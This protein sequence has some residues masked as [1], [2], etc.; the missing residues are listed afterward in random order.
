MA[1]RTTLRET[2]RHCLHRLGVL[3]PLRVLRHG[4]V[5]R[6]V[7]ETLQDR[8]THIYDAGIWKTAPTDP[9]SGAGSHPDIARRLGARLPALVRDLG[10][11]HFLDVGCGDFGW[12]KDVELGCAYTG[13]DIV[14]H[15]VAQ[16]AERF[17]REDRRFLLLNAVEDPLPAADIV[18]CREVLFHLSFADARALLRNVCRSGAGWLLATTDSVTR[19][20]ADIESGDFRILNLAAAPFGFPEPLQRLADDG[21][22]DGRTVGVWSIASLPPWD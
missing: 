16:N 2:A 19:F 9:L 3:E 12:M 5:R 4:T 21:L 8:F 15:V 17:G 7:G 6:G 1:L 14:P 13:V 18:L 22:V 11:G 20:N 10:A